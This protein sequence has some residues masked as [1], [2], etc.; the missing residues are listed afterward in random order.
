MLQPYPAVCPDDCRAVDDI[1]ILPH[2]QGSDQ[3]ADAEDHHGPHRIR[4]PESIPSDAHQQD[5]DV[6]DRRHGDP[7]EVDAERCPNAESIP[8]RKPRCIHS[9][10]DPDEQDE[11][12]EHD[13]DRQP[14]DAIV[15]REDPSDVCDRGQ[16]EI[17]VDPG[18]E[19]FPIRLFVFLPDPELVQ[20]ICQEEEVDHSPDRESDPGRSE[21][22]AILVRRRPRRHPVDGQCIREVIHVHHGD[23]SDRHGKLEDELVLVHDRAV[24]DERML[25]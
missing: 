16:E 9:I 7:A 20:G 5:G 11:E 3:S 14:D 12:H 23:I 17:R 6:R 10:G 8:S 22:I 4:N 18:K 25:R 13:Q 24:R 21:E 19:P 15:P 1:A 2:A